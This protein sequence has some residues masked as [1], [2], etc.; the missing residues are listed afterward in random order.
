MHA[1]GDSVVAR[2]MHIQRPAMIDN[3]A[4]LVFS[5]LIIY[6]VY[7]AIRLDRLLP[8]FSADSDREAASLEDTPKK[9]RR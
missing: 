2:H 9:N 4:I 1:C 6:T 8:W 5:A 7:R 3:V